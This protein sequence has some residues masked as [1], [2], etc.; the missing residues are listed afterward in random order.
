M[1]GVAIDEAVPPGPLAAWLA[2]HVPGAA[3][4]V[5]VDQLSG[6]SSNLTFRVRDDANDWVLRRPP[7]GQVLATAHDV[8]REFRVQDRLSGSAVPVP[9]MVAACSDPSV[10]G[11]PF[12][13]METLD[14]VVYADTESVSHLSDADAASASN[15]LVDVLA[16]L[17]AVDAGAA[18]LGDL[19]RPDGF[20]ERQVGRWCTQWETAKQRDLPAIDAVAVR[21]RAALPATSASGIVHGDYSFNNTMWSREQPG[22]MLAVLDWEMATLGDPLTDLGMLVTYWGPV[23]ELLWRNRD[24][25][26]HRAKAGFPGPDALIDRYARASGRALDDI[27]FYRVLATFKLAVI[28]EG[29][30]ARMAASGASPRRMATTAA[31]VAELAEAALAQSAGL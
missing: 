21:L 28:A 2:A 5:Q 29:A 27:D 16:R 12:Y 20:L 3:G 17:H 13:L 19:G 7:M 24:P 15:R 22:E 9:A 6:G 8:G 4:P 11:A 10:I 31:T 30:H 1:T 23:G 18:G 26:A 25:Q 14:G